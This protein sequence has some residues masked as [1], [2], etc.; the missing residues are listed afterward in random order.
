MMDCERSRLLWNE[1]DS[2]ELSA[3]EGEEVRTHVSGCP[4]CPGHLEAHRRSI[5]RLRAALEPLRVGRRV[6]WPS[7]GGR[8][9]IPAAAAVLFVALVIL[10]AAPRATVRVESGRVRGAA[11]LGDSLT[12]EQTTVIA[13]G[14]GVRVRLAPGTRVRFEKSDVV[15]MESGEAW[16][17]VTPGRPLRVRT[18][19]G[20]VRVKGTQFL[21]RLPKEG[22]SMRNGTL[23]VLVISGVVL[24]TRGGE[25]AEVREG[26]VLRAA[27]GRALEHFVLEAEVQRAEE[28]LRKAGSGEGTDSQEP[29]PAV[30]GADAEAKRRE[31]ERKYEELSKGLDG[32]SR[33]LGKMLLFR[34]KSAEAFL[35]NMAE[36]LAIGFLDRRRGDLGLGDED[37]GRLVELMRDGAAGIAAL[38]ARCLA[39]ETL[40]P[41]DGVAAEE[42]VRKV[43]D[44]IVEGQRKAFEELMTKVREQFGPQ[45]RKSIESDP[46]MGY[47]D[48]AE[49]LVTAL[50]G[51]MR[52]PGESREQL[53]R[54][55]VGVLGPESSTP[56]SMLT[57]MR[58]KSEI[59]EIVT[60]LRSVAGL[61]PEEQRTLYLKR[62]EVFLPAYRRQGEMLEQIVEI[63]R[64]LHRP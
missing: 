16:F 7:F 14:D 63:A 49:N 44:G 51:G 47:G 45:V 28:A 40:R 24:F 53:V 2:G 57:S 11:K 33:A 48:S 10:S 22:A 34:P 52:M 43:R 5:A 35:R 15:A 30:R 61:V 12:A 54:T 4:V 58:T 21:V 56:F 31:L 6:R 23:T 8:G 39:V 26:E 25:T 27:P 38:E 32:M 37:Y 3:V 41:Y 20:D 17:G 1:W 36:N 19:W 18:A 42:A 64:E 50:L 9:W 55:L 46:P 29:A 59:E 13:L 60:R 62:L